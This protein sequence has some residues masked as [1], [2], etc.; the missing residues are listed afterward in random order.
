ME[1]LHTE[2]FGRGLGK[3]ILFQESDDSRVSLCEFGEKSREP[4]RKSTGPFETE[5]LE[6]H[7][8]VQSR[9][10]WDK[11]SG[12]TSRVARFIAEAVIDPFESVG[13]SGNDNFRAGAGHD[14]EEAVS[15][16]AE[17]GPDRTEGGSEPGMALDPICGG[18]GLAGVFTGLVEL[19]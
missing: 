10:M 15:I 18:A 7:L 6:P 9:H 19:E 17:K 4:W 5:A 8:P 16:D 12:R 11:E 13:G 1:E 3:G 14:P 2:E